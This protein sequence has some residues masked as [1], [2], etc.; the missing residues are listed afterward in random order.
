MRGIIY[1]LKPMTLEDLGL[2]I[3]VQRYAN[4]LIDLNNIDVNVDANEEP[5]KIL[6]V[7][8]LTI[9]RVI[10][11]AC[12]NILKHANASLI[13]INILYEKDMIKVT[14]KDDGAGFNT[15]KLHLNN[16]EQ[17]SSFGL[18][19]MK[20]RIS[21]LSGS[22]EIQSEKGKGTTITISVPLTNYEEEKNE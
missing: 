20:E 17:I 5:C 4:K 15:E 22:L 21:L 16:P 1:N 6:S 9:F 13:D 12:C 7:I 3:T 19:I 14:V 2:T 18:S 8:K 11:E 10:Q